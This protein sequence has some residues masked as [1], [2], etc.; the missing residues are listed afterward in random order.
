MSLDGR[1]A[2]SPG[3]LLAALHASERELGLICPAAQGAEASWAA[4][5][6][7]IARPIWP[8]FWPT[9]KARRPFAPRP[10]QSAP[11]PRAPICDSQ[12]A[13]N[14]PARAGGCGGGRTQP[15]DGRAGAGKSLMAACLPGI[16]PDLTP[17][18]ALEVDDRLGRRNAGRRAHQ[19]RP[20]FRART[21]P[22]AWP[23]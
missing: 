3:V 17:A 19:P 23:P 20:P 7:V 11:P 18:E 15:A 2:A 1:I 5:V 13:G 10:G 4:G 6:P 14:R 21:I 12:G 8:A 9:L 16:L 22:P